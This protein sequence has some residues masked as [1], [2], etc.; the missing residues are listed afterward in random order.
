MRITNQ[1]YEPTQQVD[2]VAIFSLL[3]VHRLKWEGWRFNFYFYRSI[4]TFDQI[5]PG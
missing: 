5:L 2:I 3:P 1:I 4:L